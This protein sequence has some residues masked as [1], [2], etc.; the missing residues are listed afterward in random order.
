MCGL[1]PREIRHLCENSW[2]GGHEYT[3]SQVGDM[4]MDQ[5][6]MLLTDTQSLRSAKKVR[7]KSVDPLA[8]PGIDKDGRVK[9]IAADGTPI[10]GKIGGKSKVAMLKEKIE[11]EKQA[12]R[13]NRRRR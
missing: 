3:P 8:A 11:Q 1:G 4:T 5:I 7:S 13:R 12:S 2:N 9:G 6:F 10:R